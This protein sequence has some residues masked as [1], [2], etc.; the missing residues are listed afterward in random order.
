MPW[1]TTNR[2]NF[3][4]YYRYSGLVVVIAGVI[5]VTYALNAPPA[6]THT[7]A[8]PASAPRFTALP[9]YTHDA[10]A[11]YV[12][13]ELLTHDDAKSWGRLTAAYRDKYG[14]DE[15]I[16]LILVL[17]ERA[18]RLASNGREAKALIIARQVLGQGDAFYN[19]AAV[20][21]YDAARAL[22][23][24]TA[25]ASPETTNEPDV[26]A[27]VD[28]TLA[29]IAAAS[30]DIYDP[31]QRQI[32]NAEDYLAVQLVRWQLKR[33]RPVPDAAVAYLRTRL[34]LS[35]LHSPDI[36]DVLTHFTDG[37][38]NPTR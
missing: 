1:D 38:A 8:D 20:D 12:T 15:A 21:T 3:R 37:T 10:A 6:R 34:P 7:A 11:Y 31:V 13:T 33:G 35:E 17:N 16:G 18:G 19:P 30:Y 27:W 24:L 29:R 22:E 26:D 5:I 4:H 28:R 25:T 9:R 36:E 23:Q 32:A 14:E 2:L